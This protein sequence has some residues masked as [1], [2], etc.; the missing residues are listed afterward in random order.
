[1]T[2]TSTARRELRR[3]HRRPRGRPLRRHGRGQRADRQ[4]VRGP[5]LAQAAVP[6]G[7][8]RVRRAVP[9]GR[10]RVQAARVRPPR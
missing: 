6:G 1:M 5:E 3:L 2:L 7:G 8:R 4:A 9:G 10:L